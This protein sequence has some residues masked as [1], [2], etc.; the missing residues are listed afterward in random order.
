MSVTSIIADLQALVAT[1]AS[2]KT[3][4]AVPGSLNVPQLP[5]AVTLPGA[6]EWKEQAT[7]LIRQ[8]RDYA[9]KIYV[10]PVAHSN[11]NANLALT[12]SIIDDVGAVLIAEAKEGC[13]NITD[14]EMI[15]YPMLDSGHVILE[16]AGKQ[17]HGVIFTLRIVEK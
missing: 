15:E 8:S 10:I 3:A 2:I 1:V 6:A 13:P 11:R 5:L 14:A 4:G 16:D 17:Y 12:A 7:G 9:V